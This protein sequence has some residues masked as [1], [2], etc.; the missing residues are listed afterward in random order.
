MQYHGMKSY[1]LLVYTL[2]KIFIHF[3]MKITENITHLL[4]YVE[5]DVKI[6]KVLCNT[7]KMNLM[8]KN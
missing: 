5:T 3:S 8:M 1:K 7:W 2:Y 4:H 6:F